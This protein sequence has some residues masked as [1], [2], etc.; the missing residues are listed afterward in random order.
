M[1]INVLF[2]CYGNICR[3]PLAEFVFKDMVEKEGLQDRIHVASAGTSGEHIGDPVD[4]RSAAV[5]AQH[6][7]SCEG[8]RSRRLI[9][10]DFYDYDY[11]LG[12]DRMNLDYIRSIC[13]NPGKCKIGLLLD[14][15][16]GGI[17]DD[18]YFTLDFDKAY[19]DIER[20]CRGLLEDI[21]ASL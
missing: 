5:M 8:K 21:K 3:S 18:P 7:I 17:V 16:G 12:M 10:S 19:S 9:V 15:A 11:V 20:G 2:V 1:S 4:R 13:P 14:Y 6:G